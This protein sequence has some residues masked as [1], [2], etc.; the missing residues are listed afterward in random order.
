MLAMPADLAGLRTVLCLGAH[1]DDIEIGCGAALAEIARRAPSTR[2]TWIVF[3]GDDRREAET[4]DAA[5]RLLGE[6]A[7]LQIDVARHRGSYFPAE[8]AAIKDHMEAAKDRIEPDLVLTHW[9]DDRHQDHRVVAELTWNTFRNHAIWEYEIPKYE[10]DLGRPNLYVP[11]ES[12]TADRKVAALAD[13]FRSQ[14]H[15]AWFR[16]E[17]FRSLMTLRGVECNAGSGYAE[18]F[19]ARKMILKFER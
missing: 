17:V 16:P 3:S 18:A 5:R 6:G 1:C 11:V 8:W 13:C 7:S 4:R 2:F 12:E 10:G 14:Q 9:L 15:R 19:H